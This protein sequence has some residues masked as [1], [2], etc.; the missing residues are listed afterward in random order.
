MVM[1]PKNGFGT[2]SCSAVPSDEVRRI[3]LREREST[4]ADQQVRAFA[5]QVGDLGD[6]VARQLTLHVHI[7]LLHARR[8]VRREHAAIA[9]AD[10]QAP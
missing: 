9:A 10:V 6:E 3:D 5:S 8:L 1:I 7:P 2:W 4:F